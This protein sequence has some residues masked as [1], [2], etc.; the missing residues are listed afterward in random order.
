MK[1]LEIPKWLRPKSGY[2]LHIIFGMIIAFIFF[3]LIRNQEFFKLSDLE[4][5]LSL[6]VV[7]FYSILPDIDL[8]NSKIRCILMPTILFIVLISIVMKFKALAIGLLV[9]MILMQFLKHRKFI[10][11]VTAGIIFTLPLIFYSFPLTIFAFISYLSHLLLD[12]EVK[13]I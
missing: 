3:Y 1:I 9:V 8:P 10:H 2:K 13:L 5:A 11:S 4:L 12:G 7:L 6:P